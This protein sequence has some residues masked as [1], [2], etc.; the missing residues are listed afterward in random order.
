MI[1]RAEMRTVHEWM[2]HSDVQT[3]MKYVDHVPRHD[4]AAPVAD[5]VRPARLLDENKLTER[6]RT[7]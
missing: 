7:A 5:A 2:G 1:A 6:R 3:T 4:D